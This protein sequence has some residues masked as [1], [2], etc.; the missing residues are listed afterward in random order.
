MDFIYQLRLWIGGQYC[1]VLCMYSVVR[2][3]LAAT[4]NA[5]DTVVFIYNL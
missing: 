3:C 1:I 4:L 5:H 2:C